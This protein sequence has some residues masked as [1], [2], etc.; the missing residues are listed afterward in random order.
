MLSPLPHASHTCPGRCLYHLLHNCLTH[1]PIS[2]FSS[3]P[4]AAPRKKEAGG[5]HSARLSATW[6][7]GTPV[8]APRRRASGLPSYSR[9]CLPPAPAATFSPASAICVATARCQAAALY[10]FCTR[11]DTGGRACLRAARAATRSSSTCGLVTSPNNTRRLF[12]GI[13]RL[14]PAAVVAHYLRLPATSGLP[15]IYPPFTITPALASIS[16]RCA[17]LLQPAALHS[18]TFSLTCVRTGDDAL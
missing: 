11:M 15:P 16:P 8:T 3:S 14:K 10:H 17:A 6:V 9:P 5:P 18:F 2:N 12:S 1:K 4:A 13:E 7:S